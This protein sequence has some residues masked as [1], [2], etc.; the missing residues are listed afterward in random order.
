MKVLIPTSLFAVLPPHLLLGQAVQTNATNLLSRHYQD[1]EKRSYHMKATN[2][3][4]FGTTSY[5]ADAMG[6]VKTDSSGRFFEEYSWANLIVNNKKIALP[7]ASESVRQSLSL[8]PNY[9]FSG[10]PDLTKVNPHLTGPMLDLFNFYVDLQL[11]IRQEN[12]AHAETMCPSSMANPLPG[13]VILSFSVKIRLILILLS[14]TLAK[15]V[16]LPP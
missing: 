6:V 16:K 14:K 7:A 9:G 12:L 5:E 11:A 15:P 4:F 13:R 8:D 3:G 10:F 2:K 1:G